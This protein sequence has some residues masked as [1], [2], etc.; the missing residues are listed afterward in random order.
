L[1][2]LADAIRAFQGQEKSPR[3]GASGSHW[4]ICGRQ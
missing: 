1:G 2:G 4:F 3:P